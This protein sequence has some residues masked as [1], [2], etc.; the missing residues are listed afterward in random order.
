MIFL[1]NV[2][3]LTNGKEYSTDLISY[4]MVKNRSIYLN[5][6]VNSESALSVISLPSESLA[7]ID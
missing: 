4:E 7:D 5:G 1:P 3:T 2:I 6:E